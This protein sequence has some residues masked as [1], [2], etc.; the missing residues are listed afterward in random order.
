MSENCRAIAIDEYFLNL[1]ATQYIELYKQ[2]YK[3][4]YL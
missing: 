4:K 1:Q 2:V 3:K